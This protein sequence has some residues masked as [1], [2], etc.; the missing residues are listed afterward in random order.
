MDGAI[1]HY[2][3]AGNSGKAIEAA[4]A[5]QQWQKAQDILEQTV[6]D[7]ETHAKYYKEER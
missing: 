2:I 1:N 5:A 7:T 4:I 6:S 3:E